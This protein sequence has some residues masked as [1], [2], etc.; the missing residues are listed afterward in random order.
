MSRVAGLREM[1][2]PIIRARARADALEVADVAG[3]DV[4]AFDLEDDLWGLPLLSPKKSLFF[5]SSLV[6][7]LRE[8]APAA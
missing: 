8:L 1:N 2:A 5:Q 6:R 3:F 7:S 4:A